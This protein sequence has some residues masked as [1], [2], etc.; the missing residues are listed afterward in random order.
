MLG[1]NFQILGKS[2]HGPNTV[3]LSWYIC[4]RSQNEHLRTFYLSV[5]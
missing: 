4:L 5:R 3:S 1:K 2:L